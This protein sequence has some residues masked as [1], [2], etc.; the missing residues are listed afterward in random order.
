MADFEPSGPWKAAFRAAL[1]QAFDQPGFAVLISDYFSPESFDGL[2]PPGFGKNIDF[3]FM[4][5]IEQA[6]MNGWLVDLASA[7]YERRPTQTALRQI[8]EDLGLT[9][10]GSRLIN[11]AGQT[12]EALIQERAAFINPALLRAR[13]AEL[14]GQ[15]CFVEIPGGRGGTGFLVGP[16]L[17]LTNEHV[18]L[19][20]IEKTVSWND[21]ICRFD[22]RL[23]SDGSELDRKKQVVVKLLSAD[24]WLVD[25]A[26]PSPHD[27]DPTS[28]GNAAATE[29]DYALIRLAE[30]IGNE[31]I[32]GAVGDPNATPRSWIAATKTPV[33][34]VAAGNQIFVLQHPAGQPQQ[35]TVGMVTS[36]NGTGTRVRYDANSK[37]GS[38]GAP[39][40][41]ADLELVALHHAHDPNDPPA[42][43]Q[44]VPFAT[45][46]KI[47]KH[48]GR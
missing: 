38:S 24:G 47:W 7:A 48:P 22:Y 12:F 2:S 23:A 33:P 45:I 31:P 18:M 44:G 34:A 21:V 43:N 36:F 4:E 41:N 5:V 20:L 30:A 11:P 1:K 35:L 14:E 32:R 25:S 42:W 46:Q 27:E 3:R 19:P 8:A 16:D 6:R 10:T 29:C 39:V 28:A 9:A 37:E 40:F 13:L 26:P 17:V 15:I